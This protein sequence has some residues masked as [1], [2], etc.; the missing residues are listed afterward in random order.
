MGYLMKRSISESTLFRPCG[1]YVQGCWSYSAGRCP[2]LT[3]VRPTAFMVLLV[4]LLT[5][6]WY[7]ILLY[8]APSGVWGAEGW[9][10]QQGGALH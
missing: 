10:Y 1:A 8:S 5:T 3:Y 6:E 2:A 4:V 7:H 9:P